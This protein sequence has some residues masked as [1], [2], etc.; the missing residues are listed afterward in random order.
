MGRK[1]G[2]QQEQALLLLLIF[3]FSSAGIDAFVVATCKYHPNHPSKVTFTQHKPICDPIVQ[4]AIASSTMEALEGFWRSSPYTA[5]GIVCGIKAAAAD[6]IVQKKT[7]MTDKAKLDIKRNLAFI[8]YGS[9]YQ[10]ICQEYIYN[11]LYPLWFGHGTNWQVVL[12]KVSF[13]CLI[14]TTVITLP[15]AYLVKATI[16]RHSFRKAMTLYVID[17]KK[18]GLLKKYFSLWAPVN[19][20]TFSVVPEHYRV[21]WIA[22]VSFFWLMILS[23]IS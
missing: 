7:K 15:V 13:D 22:C 19:C 23:S 9:M 20:L 16:Y 5:A 18:R 17:V 3:L 4:R 14:Q 11:H 21:T 8:F 10:G 1:A 12:T 6:L 2:F